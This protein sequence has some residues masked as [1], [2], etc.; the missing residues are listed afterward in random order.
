MSSKVLTLVN[1]RIQQSVDLFVRTTGDNVV[2]TA[3]G[4]MGYVPFYT[5]AATVSGDPAL[6][7]DNTNKRLGIG[8]T[9]P[10]ALLH[11]YKTA[12]G[13]GAAADF[14][15]TAAD[16]YARLRFV[17]N[18]RIF[19]WVTEGT[20]GTAFPG[21]LGLYDY[22]SSAVRLTIDSTGN[23]GIGTIAPDKKFHVVSAT[24]G[25]WLYMSYAA[26]GIALGNNA[27]FAS[28][29]MYGFLAL[30]TGAGHYGLAAGDILLGAQ[31]NSRGNIHINANYSGTGTTHVILQ[32]STG[33]VGIGTTAPGATT[34]LRIVGLTSAN[35]SV[36]LYVLNN[37]STALMYVQDDGVLWANRAWVVSDRRAK[38]NITSS[39]LG[40]AEIRKL[41][42]RKYD[43]TLVPQSNQLGFLSDE[44][45]DWIPESIMP[46]KICALCGRMDGE[47]HQGATHAFSAA[48]SMDYAAIIPVLVRAVQELDVE[49]TK[50]KNKP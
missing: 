5:S 32:P 22:T 50:L 48:M 25:E 43:L 49:V 38:T 10:S 33:S 14:E 45:I 30:A 17:T 39:T 18:S 1:G 47:D 12:A 42:P 8:T 27:V 37:G 19:G 35:T 40:I 20:A 34:K 41:K 44:V 13:A 23:V 7:W 15:T 26:P 46:S 28:A 16:G 2:F 31:G 29:T 21:K 4:V 9:A 6:V 24:V 36:A 11:L 3:S